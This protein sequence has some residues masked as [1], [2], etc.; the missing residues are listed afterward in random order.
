MIR[1]ASLSIAAVLFAAAAAPMLAKA[2]MIV[3]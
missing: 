1:F 2:A 3:A